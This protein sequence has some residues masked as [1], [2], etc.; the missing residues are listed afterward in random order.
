VKRSIARIKPS[1]PAAP[2]SKVST[3][4]YTCRSGRP[5]CHCRPRRLYES[6]SLDRIVHR[7][8]V[9][10]NI[11]RT[12]PAMDHL[13][14]RLNY[15]YASPFMIC[16]CCRAGLR[17]IGHD[18]VTEIKRI[19]RVSFIRSSSVCPCPSVVVTLV[20]LDESLQLD[21]QW[22]GC[23]PH[24]TRYRHLTPHAPV[25]P[26]PAFDHVLPTLVI[27][28]DADPGSCYGSR[29][30]SKSFISISRCVVLANAVE[31]R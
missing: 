7:L 2:S 31:P 14:D 8:D 23:P 15:P 26:P 12:H 20:L 3:P 4:R 16:V 25:I 6:L 19:H 17:S 1:S 5:P 13:S 30:R 11:L 22:Q 27:R 9:P 18:K 28:S 24:K 21:D 10:K 29:F